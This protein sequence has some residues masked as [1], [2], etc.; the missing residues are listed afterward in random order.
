MSE[1]SRSLCRPGLSAFAIALGPFL[2][3]IIVTIQGE[4]ILQCSS[5]NQ[6]GNKA[7]R[8]HD[9]GT[10][11]ARSG[12]AKIYRHPCLFR[13]LTDHSYDED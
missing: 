4:G 1:P 7:Y 9:Y 8:N 3:S 10:P 5:A 6:V 12:L 13:F 11:Y 2:E